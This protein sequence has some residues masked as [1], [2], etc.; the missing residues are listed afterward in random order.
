MLMYIHIADILREL[1]RMNFLY[2]GLYFYILYFE[3][4]ITTTGS[5]V[6]YQK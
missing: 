5:K 4:S 2:Y 6:E 3:V 1:F